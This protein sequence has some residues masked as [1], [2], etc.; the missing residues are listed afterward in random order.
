VTDVTTPLE[1]GWNDLVL[2]YNQAYGILSLALQITAGPDLSGAPIPQARLRAV[3]PRSDR[4]ATQTL[5]GSARSIAND[6]GVATT[7]VA[8][9]DGFA[10]EVV[11]ELDVHADI[12]TQHQ[13]QLVF[14]LTKPGGSPVAI[15]THQGVGSGGGGTFPVEIVVTDPAL[16]GGPPAGNWTLGIADDVVGGNSSTVSGFALTVHASG[17]PEQIALSGTWT[18][19]VLDTQS[20]VRGIAQVMWNERVPATRSPTQVTLRTCDQ[21]DC[22]DDPPWSGAIAKNAG[23][24][25]PTKRYLQARVVMSSDG[26]HEPELDSLQITYAHD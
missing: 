26:T 1:A 24:T 9:I 25:I 18:S 15:R 3:E 20:I 19:G 23:T 22:S 12:A 6:S 8:K 2:D 4:L 14:Y 11:T 17:G 21:P 5:R 7:T 10:T 16:I 13:E